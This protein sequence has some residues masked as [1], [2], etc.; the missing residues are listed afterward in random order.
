MNPI[1][2]LA[3]APIVVWIGF[4]QNASTSSLTLASLISQP[5][6]RPEL[7]L[8]QDNLAAA[9]SVLQQLRADPTTLKA[10]LLVAEGNGAY[11]QASLAQIAAQTRFTLSQ[12]YLNAV[13]AEAKQQLDQ[14]RL[15][16]T[17]TELKVAQERVK[18]GS[19]NVLAIEQAKANLVQ[20]QQD[21]K[22]D[23]IQL[24]VQR[25]L[26]SNLLAAQNLP[27]LEKSLPTTLPVPSLAVLRQAARGVPAVVKAQNALELARLRLEQTQS[28]YVPQLQRTSAQQT[29]ITA[30]LDYQAQLTLAQQA[31]DSA[32]VAA[33]DA[34]A[35]LEAAQ[36]ALAAQQAAYQ[37]AQSQEKVGTVSRIQVSTLAVSF[38]QARLALLQA[39]QQGY[40]AQLNLELVAPGGVK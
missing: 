19:G 22:V 10:D 26:L 7:K 33:L 39:Q 25:D 1:R 32:Y 15:E 38:E 11:A 40:L 34:K 20:V 13:A 16:L 21:L 23:A 6:P 28:Q 36:A 9:Q 27:T 35:R 17:Q 29:L 3:L 14:T 30:Q 4:A 18:L 12:A 2:L 8:A 37:T 24:G 31:V 5:L